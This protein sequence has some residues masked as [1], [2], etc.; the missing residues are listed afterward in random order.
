MN[1]KQKVAVVV[2]VV[3]LLLDLTSCGGPD[4][5]SRARSAEGAKEVRIG[6][7]APGDLTEADLLDTREA[8]REAQGAAA[9]QG[10]GIDQPL[11][12]GHI[13]SVDDG[14][15]AVTISLGTVD[16]VKPGFRYT[17]S[18]GIQYVAMIEI[19]DVQAKVSAGRSIKS[20]QKTDIQVGDRVMSR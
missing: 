11:H 9:D 4:R 20:L 8:L 1:R 16:G 6:W 18:R 10:A 19:M 3:V 13:V 17:V 14:T 2:G 5:G 12:E 15:D 7:G